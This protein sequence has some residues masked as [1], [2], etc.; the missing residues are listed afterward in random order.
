MRCRLN[1]RPPQ[2]RRA[3]APRRHLAAARAA[4]NHRNDT[5]RQKCTEWYKPLALKSVGAYTR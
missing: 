5:T 4:E 2:C 3:D 1:Q